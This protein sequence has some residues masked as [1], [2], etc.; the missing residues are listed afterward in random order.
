M[1]IIILLSLVYAF[2]TLALVFIC[3]LPIISGAGSVWY[4]C[5][6]DFGNILNSF[7]N[8]LQF[9]VFAVMSVCLFVPLPVSGVCFRNRLVIDAENFIYASEMKLLFSFFFLYIYV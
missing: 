2:P 7:L 1:L 6:T 9:C 3:H 8:P 5:G 4:D